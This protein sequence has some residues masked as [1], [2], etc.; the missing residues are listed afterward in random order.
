MTRDTATLQSFDGQPRQTS[1]PIDL[2]YTS[3]ADRPATIH[4]FDIS[5]LDALH[6]VLLATDGTVTNVIEA[7]A[8]EPVRVHVL[9]SPTSPRACEHLRG[10]LSPATP[11]NARGRRV[12]LQ[13]AHSEQVYAVATSLLAVPTETGFGRHLGAA[14][15]GIGEALRTSRTESYREL[16]WYGATT[17]DPLRTNTTEALP[18]AKRAPSG[19]L[20][21]ADGASAYLTRV[22]RIVAEGAPVAV[23]QES[24]PRA[25]KR[26]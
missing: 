13:G 26:L 20:S 7:F 12:A 8:L 23:I 17:E 4:D 6:R 14:R 25:R 18:A 15:K 1:A 10:W 24:F 2:A 19:D 5:E 3:Q 16:L 21:S 11:S 22:Y 9:G